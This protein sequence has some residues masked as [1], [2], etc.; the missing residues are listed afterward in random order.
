M[1]HVVVQCLFGKNVD[2]ALSF[3]VWRRFAGVED[4][5]ITLIYKGV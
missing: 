5:R 2:G 3:V 1:K 4:E